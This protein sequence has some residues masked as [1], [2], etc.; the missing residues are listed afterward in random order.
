MFD[1]ASAVQPLKVSRCGKQKKI[2]NEIA[3]LK[4]MQCSEKQHIPLYLQ[5]RDKGFKYFP[6]TCFIS[7]IRNVDKCVFA[8][9]SSLAQYSSRVVKVATENLKRNSDLEVD[10]NTILKEVYN[11]NSTKNLYM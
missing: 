1:D 8:T 9:E 6:T 4:A 5:H 7:F 3:I 11:N 2:K 10:F